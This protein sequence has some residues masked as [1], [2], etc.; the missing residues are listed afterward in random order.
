MCV[1]F[2]STL[3][4]WPIG[5]LVIRRKGVRSQPRLAA[6][7]RCLAWAISALYL[8]FLVL[9]VVGISDLSITPLAKAA[10]AVA[11]VATA[12][13]AGMVACAG[14]AWKWHYWS[15][16]GRAHY[17]LVTLGALTF[18]WFLN[19]WNLLGFRW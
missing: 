7:A 2:L 12:L 9:F 19:Y 3:V 17:T 14:L 16:V 11:L 13:T 4:V 1:L 15:V 8:L 10:L 5:W 6:V 18:I